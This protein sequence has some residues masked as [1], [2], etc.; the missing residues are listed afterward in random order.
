MTSAGQPRILVLG[1]GSVGRRHARNIQSLG[2]AITCFDPRSDRLEQ[3]LEEL[4]RI[5]VF[6]DLER[7]LDKKYEGVVIASPP[8]FHV[9]QAIDCLER[10]LPILL[11]KP[12]S[13]DLE[14]ALRLREAAARSSTPILLGYT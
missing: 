3:S 2:A 6:D 11:E 13:P 1:A 12:I 10:S 4:E 14:S 5:E 7:A 8:K 9:D